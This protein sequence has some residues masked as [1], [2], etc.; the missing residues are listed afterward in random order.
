MCS[1]VKP[2]IKKA[3]NLL[4]DLISSVTYERSRC[5][6]TLFKAISP[7][8]EFAT[9][10]FSVFL[11]QPDV[12]EHLMGFFLTLFSSLK[13]QVTKVPFSVDGID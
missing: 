4:E 9:T 5:K 7:T 10:L 2:D 12:L 13:V 1:T 8:V 11:Q 3:L 6:A